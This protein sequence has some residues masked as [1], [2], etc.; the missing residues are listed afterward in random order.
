VN[1]PLGTDTGDLGADV[2]IAGDADTKS[3]RHLS[4]GQLQVALRSARGAAPHLVVAK[5]MNRGRQE[6]AEVP[7]KVSD[8]TDRSGS[9][10]R[11]TGA[12]RIWTSKM[13]GLH[14]AGALL[15]A[16]KIRRKRDAPVD[17][18]PTEGVWNAPGLGWSAS[19]YTHARRWS[20]LL[21]VLVLLMVGAVTVAG[22]VLA[23]VHPAP[24]VVPVALRVSDLQFGGTAEAAV[25]DY[26]SWDQA[27]T[28]STRINALGRWG[29]TGAISDA[30]DG[31][32][33]LDTKNAVAIAV[34]RVSD[35]RAVVTVQARTAHRESSPATDLG[36]NDSNP[37]GPPGAAM[38]LTL[39]VPV[40]VYGSRILVTAP[41]AIVGSPPTQAQ[42]PAVATAADEDTDTGRATAETVN[43]LI[44]A[45]GSGDLEFARGPESNF[46]G[47]TGMVTS[48]EV[49][50][51]RMAKIRAGDD[52]SLR[53]G[54]VTVMWRLPDGAGQL[55]C[56]YRIQLA[57]R[58][59]R[60]LMQQIAPALGKS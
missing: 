55:R 29:F 32:G 8:D 57:Q 50:S 26:L 25:L 30:W 47:L 46:T 18:S 35:D 14:N 40:A 22:R 45:Y 34:L 43:K 44:A 24:V 20:T 39:A 28:R 48:G 54:D 27:T 37:S 58:E 36:A 31:T 53:S 59:N 33:K 11:A 16:R 56:S 4:I 3:E 60:W 10:R 42:G 2:N 51:W 38:W 19:F 52:P 41:P 13:L 12:F 7:G 17:S 1:T 23:I 5:P 21:V 6:H 9:S 15:A 49:Q